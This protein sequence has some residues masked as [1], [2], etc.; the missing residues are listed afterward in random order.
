M[1]RVVAEAPDNVR[2]AY[3]ELENSSFHLGYKMTLDKDLNLQFNNNDPYMPSII[4]NRIK[5][6]EETYYLVDVMF[7]VLHSGP[8]QFAD[9]IEHYTHKF[10]EVGKFITQINRFVYNPNKYED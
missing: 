6:G 10:Y 2:A 5:D 9:T 3:S 4:T 8:D 1:K 7:P